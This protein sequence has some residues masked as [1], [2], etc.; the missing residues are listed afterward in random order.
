MKYQPLPDCGICPIFPIHRKITIFSFNIFFN[1]FKMNCGGDDDTSS[2]AEERQRHHF[3][4]FY[5]HDCIVC[6]IVN[7]TTCSQKKKNMKR[8]C[9]TF[10]SIRSVH[11]PS[12]FC[13][14]Y[15]MTF[16]S[17]ESLMSIV[18]PHISQTKKGPNGSIPNSI[19]ISAAIRYVA[20][21]SI[22]YCTIPWNIVHRSLFFC[23]DLSWIH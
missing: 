10:E 11:P 16:C 12:H 14:S 20:S 21:F 17:F 2:L 5:L 18:S 4:Y 7:S 8:N 9:C 3:V 22:W 23:V 1:I 15:W 13:S 19:M 6:I